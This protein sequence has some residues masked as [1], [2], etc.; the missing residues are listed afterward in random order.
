MRHTFVNAGNGWVLRL[1][2]MDHLI[3][4]LVSEWQARRDTIEEDIRIIEDVM[5]SDAFTKREKVAIGRTHPINRLSHT[6]RT[7]AFQMDAPVDAVMAAMSRDL[8]HSMTRAL[9]DRGCIYV[10]PYGGWRCSL[11]N[12]FEPP[13]P[14]ETYEKEGADFPIFDND[15]IRVK[16]WPGG[17]HYYVYLG[18]MPV[19]MDGKYKFDTE[20]EAESAARVQ[21]ARLGRARAERDNLTGKDNFKYVPERLASESH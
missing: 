1:D 20:F 19:C 4:Y 7:Y 16:S 18:D 2:D 15:D 3:D 8:A 17:R 6:I 11:P 10:N 12:A 14:F 9:E 13:R 21:N 5:A